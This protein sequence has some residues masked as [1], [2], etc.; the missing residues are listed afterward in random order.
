MDVLRPEFLIQINDG[1]S[2][3][4]TIAIIK[5]EIDVVTM[6]LTKDHASISFVNKSGCAMHHVLIQG[7]EI[8]YN[9]DVRDENGNLKLEHPVPFETNELANTTKGI[10]RKDGVRLYAFKGDNKFNVQPMRVSAK[11]PGRSSALF[12]NILNV[13]YVKYDPSGL[14][15]KSPHVRL[16]AKE[17]ADICCTAVTTKCSCLDIVGSSKGVTFQGIQP[18]NNA[19]S[20]NHYLSQSYKPEPAPVYAEQDWD[21]IIKTSEYAASTSAET[22]STSATVSSV[23]LRIV[24]GQTLIPIRVPIATVR[25]LSKIHNISPSNTLLKFFFLEGNPMK[26]E[27]PIW[28]YGTYTICL[29]NTGAK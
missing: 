12:V 28:T 10:G 2:F 21:S 18:N 27:S 17:F 4:N 19:V 24:S 7:K 25:S 11:E 29:K 16:Q 9:Y 8:V 5:S 6:I 3:R 20:Y 1:Y 26:I 22:A 13:E 14:Y 23:T 15:D